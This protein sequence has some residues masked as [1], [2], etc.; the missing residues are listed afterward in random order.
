MRSGYAQVGGVHRR[1]MAAGHAPRRHAR[2]G[3]GRRGPWRAPP[4]HPPTPP[5]Q[6][7]GSTCW[8]VAGVQAFK[9]VRAMPVVRASSVRPWLLVLVDDSV[10]PKLDIGD[11]LGS[12]PIG[13]SIGTRYRVPNP[14]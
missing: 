3:H 10:V 14:D 13:I 6:L 8:L 4:P 12:G 2:P 1:G 5:L 7:R 9:G 11:R